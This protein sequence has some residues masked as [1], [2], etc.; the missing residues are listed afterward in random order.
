LKILLVT[1]S[2][3]AIVAFQIDKSGSAPVYLIDGRHRLAQIIT[4]M[5]N[6]DA[7]APAPTK[8]GKGKNSVPA[9]LTKLTANDFK[10]KNNS[11][12]WPSGFS[13]LTVKAIVLPNSAKLDDVTL[14]KIA[15]N[16]NNRETR[17]SKNPASVIVCYYYRF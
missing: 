1:D 7:P 16:C 10:G 2:F 6:S 5:I 12:A 3:P 13:A 15:D 14:S 11:I 17:S 8:A 9:P 4:V